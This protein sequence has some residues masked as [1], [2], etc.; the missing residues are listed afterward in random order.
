MKRYKEKA[1]II[2]R[3]SAIALL[4]VALPATGISGTSDKKS[5]TRLEDA[6]KATTVEGMDF[7]TSDGQDVGNID[8]IVFSTKTGE[9]TDLIVDT[10]ILGIGG[11]EHRISV[12][13]LDGPSIDPYDMKTS[14]SVSEFRDTPKF[15]RSKL[16]K[17]RSQGDSDVMRGQILAMDALGRE[18]R[19]ES[20]EHLGEVNDWI[21]DVENNNV[22]YLIVERLAPFGTMSSVTGYNYFAI[23]SSRV[24]GLEDGDIIASVSLED[25]TGAES[26]DDDTPLS[27]SDRDA[28]IYQFKYDASGMLSQK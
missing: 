5:H 23:A 26:V 2:T 7:H 3:I 18:V 22:P 8:D 4:A 20:G 1:N 14:L 11:T 19:A 25:L 28:P 12:D 27:W 21:V 15:E 10:G 24:V 9:I 16:E 17:S 6:A 13:K